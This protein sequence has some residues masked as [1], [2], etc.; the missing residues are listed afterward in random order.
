[1]ISVLKLWWT[2]KPLKA[3][4][5]TKTRDKRRGDKVRVSS[6][7][8]Q[9]WSVD[10]SHINTGRSHSVTVWTPSYNETA[11]TNVIRAIQEGRKAPGLGIEVNTVASNTGT[12]VIINTGNRVRQKCKTKDF[13]PHYRTGNIRGRCL[14][15][16]R[17]GNIWLPR[18]QSRKQEVGA[19]EL[20]ADESSLFPRKVLRFVWW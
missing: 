10:C 8:S 16:E 17:Y 11:S 14:I 15:H 1:M 3:R 2:Y 4:I 13:V 18:W 12:L 6:I 20:V 19:A 9:R 7:S 5:L